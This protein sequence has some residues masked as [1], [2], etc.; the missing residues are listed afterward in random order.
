MTASHFFSSRF[1]FYVNSAIKRITF[2]PADLFSIVLQGQNIIIIIRFCFR[3]RYLP[4]SSQLENTKDLL[5]L[6]RT[7]NC[8]DMIRF[9][10]LWCLSHCAFGVAVD[11]WA[12][13]ELS[14]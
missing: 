8:S 9:C 3:I 10:V 12:L 2:N 5:L 4:V 14:K 11:V 6:V 7:P 1:D 13:D